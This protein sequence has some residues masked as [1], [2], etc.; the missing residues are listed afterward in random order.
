MYR[1]GFAL[2]LIIC[3][4]A[5]SATNDSATDWLMRMNEAAESLSYQGTFIYLYDNQ[6]ETMWVAR[7]VENGSTRER[8]FALNGEPREIIRDNEQVWCYLPDQRIGVHEYRQVAERS[9]PR[10]LPDELSD[11][12]RLYEVEFGE[13]GIERLANR[14]ARHIVVKPIDELRYGY[15]LWA[16]TETGL[17]LRAVLMQPGGEPIE[18]YVFTQIDVDSAVPAGALKPRTAR[19]SLKW[20]GVGKEHEQT[21][22]GELTWQVAPLPSGFRLVKHLR[23]RDP[24]SGEPIEHIVLSDGLAAVSVFV[25]SAGGSGQ[26]PLT[27]V[28]RMGAVHAFGRM[29]EGF[30]VTVVGE[31]PETTVTRIGQ[32]VSRR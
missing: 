7:S 2:L 30:Q 15:D 4:G 11:L 22:T 26:Q 32:A 9:F 28:S 21:D 6:V 12:A 31:V 19:E 17:L 14:D 1:L 23:R 29:V 18:Q 10:L 25:S 16:D 3:Q 24:M 5:A 8:L 13:G 27:G 20:Y